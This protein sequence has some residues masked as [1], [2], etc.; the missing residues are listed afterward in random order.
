MKDDE[1]KE[2]LVTEKVTSYF[3]IFE[4]GRNLFN[5]LDVTYQRGH[6]LMASP[7]REE[8][9]TSPARD[10]YYEQ[11]TK[12]LI[13]LNVESDGTINNDKL[14]QAI[15]DLKAEDKAGHVYEKDPQ[16]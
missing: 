7:V 10:R 9:Y 3:N 5:Q 11:L 12:S 13:N 8:Y 14:N 6:E 15:T 16:T 2:P 1:H 4:C